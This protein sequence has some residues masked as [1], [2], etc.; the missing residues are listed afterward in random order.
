MQWP[1]RHPFCRGFDAATSGDASALRV[2]R[3]RAWPLELQ[4]AMATSSPI[5]PRFRRGNIWGCVRPPPALPRGEQDGN[6]TRRYHMQTEQRRA[7]DLRK[8]CL[9]APLRTHDASIPAPNA[10]CRCLGCTRRARLW[11]ERSANAGRGGCGSRRRASRW[12]RG[13]CGGRRRWSPGRGPRARRGC[14]GDLSRVGARLFRI[15]KRADAAAVRPG[16]LPERYW[17]VSPRRNSHWLSLRSAT[18]YS[19][20]VPRRIELC[21][22]GRSLSGQARAPVRGG[23]NGCGGDCA[24]R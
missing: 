23:W 4:H 12:R 6:H 13:R 22:R 20:L 21:R 10:D 18:I 16:D 9:H 1:P 7:S 11:G 19:A 8:P 3:R 24:A 5:L 2:H 14:F 15:R 17:A